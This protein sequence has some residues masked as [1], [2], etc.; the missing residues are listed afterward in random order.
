MQD[1]SQ[2]LYSALHD[3][4]PAWME[5][6]L[7]AWQREILSLLFE[8]PQK[9]M[10]RFH[11]IEQELRTAIDLPT[12]PTE[13]ALS[14][15]V[16]S[17][18]RARDEGLLL[19]DYL[20]SVADLEKL[21][22]WES[23]QKMIQ[24]EDHL[25]GRLESTLKK[26]GS[27]W[28][29]GIRAA[30][31]IG[32]IQRVPEGIQLSADETIR[33]SGHAGRRLAEAW[34]AAFGIDPDPT[35]AYGLAVK[36]VEDAALTKVPLRPSDHKTLGSVIRVLNGPGFDAADWTLGFRREDKHYSN[37]QTLV[38]MLKT[39]WSGQT[40]RHGGD[41]EYVSEAV[42]SQKAAESAVM[43]AVPLVNWFT[44]GFVVTSLPNE[45]LAPE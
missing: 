8:N 18:F 27:K 30:G 5:K 4:V 15:S 2:N 24:E 12:N 7:R 1:D 19:T 26:S 6:S 44:S 25:F 43:L 13:Y 16:V 40:D 22:G 11:T 38:A 34:G 10:K 23:L 21:G 35:K 14:V 45:K 29:V 17:H 9:A 37:G 31:R 20:L 36:A 41:H 39:L 3:G 28:A 32:L 33:K 42:I